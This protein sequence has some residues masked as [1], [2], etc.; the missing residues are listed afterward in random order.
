ML[1]PFIGVSA[2]RTLIPPL[3]QD[4]RTIT[5]T[6]E[7]IFI[8]DRACFSF[9]SAKRCFER[10]GLPGE[11]EKTVSQVKS[12]Q[13]SRNCS[14]GVNHFRFGASILLPGP[15]YSRKSFGVGN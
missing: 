7:D 11:W 4:R 1:F 10:A 14:A 6:R 15:P 8:P 13:I 2:D 12:P 5:L 3:E 9:E